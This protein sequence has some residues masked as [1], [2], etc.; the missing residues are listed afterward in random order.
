MLNFN[1]AIIFSFFL[2]DISSFASVVMKVHKSGA[3]AFEKEP[4][5]GSQGNFTIC[6]FRSGTI[7]RSATYFLYFFL[8]GIN[9]TLDPLFGFE[10]LGS[11]RS[12]NSIPQASKFLSNL[13]HII[14]KLLAIKVDMPITNSFL[15]SAFMLVSTQ[16]E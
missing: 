11:T 2:M 4:T 3:S 6:F 8:L 13:K 16:E 5:T 12:V 15:L 7:I 1:P 9:N 10:M 14:Y